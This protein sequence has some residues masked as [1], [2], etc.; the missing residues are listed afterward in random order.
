MNPRCFSNTINFPLHNILSYIQIYRCW[1]VVHTS[2]NQN[3]IIYNATY[4][5]ML[6][7][8]LFNLS[9]TTFCTPRE[10]AELLRAKEA[11]LATTA[12]A[13]IR[14]TLWISGSLHWILGLQCLSNSMYNT[15]QQKS[16]LTSIKIVINE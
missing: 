1:T 9:T 2:M 3:I 4:S 5:S 7:H 11:K 13:L 8:A 14:N 10:Q 6:L 16:K 12:P 15:I